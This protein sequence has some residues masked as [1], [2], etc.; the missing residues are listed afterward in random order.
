MIA[1][2][3]GELV[4]ASTPQVRIRRKI[5]SDAQDEYRWRM[6]PDLARFDAATPPPQTFEEFLS[7]FEYDLAFGRAAREAF[8]L[9]SNEGMHI[10]TVMYYNASTE[11]AELGVSIAPEGYRGRGVGRATIVAFLRFLFAQRSFRRIHL[12]TLE[13]NMRAIKCFEACGFQAIERIFHD[14][15]WFVVME[16][17][18]EWW[19]L[20]DSEGRFDFPAPAESGDQSRE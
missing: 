2:P 17:R 4:V 3:T 10:G 19:L 6:D 15:N 12:R 7:V 5:R 20:W 14:G 8:A 16:A 18:R 11:S 13:W 9:E 1:P